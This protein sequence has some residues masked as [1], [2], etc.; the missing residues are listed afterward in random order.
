V[1]AQSSSSDSVV[2]SKWASTS[3]FTGS[4]LTADGPGLDVGDAD[5]ESVRS[6]EGA[7]TVI[8][9]NDE[10]F[11]FTVGVFVTAFG[12]AE[13]S[14][15]FL[16]PARERAPDSVLAILSSPAWM[17]SIRCCRSFGTLRVRDTGVVG[18]A[19]VVRSGVI[20]DC[21]LGAIWDRNERVGVETEQSG[22]DDGPTLEARAREHW[23]YVGAV[24]DGDGDNVAEGWKTGR[25]LWL[26][27]RSSSQTVMK[28]DQL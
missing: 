24:S 9:L 28:S 23:E 14:L 17:A 20:G 12:N 16:S 26:G 15:L 4:A 7:G 13:G 22:D 1:F 8:G 27:E 21:G 19:L 25:W 11:I 5:V 2:S 3:E 10:D 18:F 6:E